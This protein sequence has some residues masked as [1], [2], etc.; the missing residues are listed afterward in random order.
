LQFQEAHVDFSNLDLL[1]GA[2]MNY[3]Q[4]NLIDVPSMFQPRF[5]RVNIFYSN[6]DYYTDQKYKESTTSAVG[7]IEWPVKKDDFF[8][9]SDCPH[10]FWTGYFT[11]RAAFKRFERVASSFLLAARQLD[12]LAP[13]S[14]TTHSGRKDDEN[15][16]F[17]LEDALGIAQHHDAISG[18]AKQH[19]VDDYS[20]QLS[21]GMNSAA[22]HAIQA[23]KKLMLGDGLDNLSY[24]P[25]LNETVCQVSEV[26]F[27]VSMS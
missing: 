25:L 4:W 7:A 8:P 16:L 11:S 6:P 27:C 5:D 23:L 17:A 12:A 2:T 15:P 14:T 19:V 13:A 22:L 9:Y 24:C 10:C 3:Q 21:A 26:S 20:K 18:T 1:I